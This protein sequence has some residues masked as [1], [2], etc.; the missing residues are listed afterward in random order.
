MNTR[1]SPTPPATG[2]IRQN[3]SASPITASQANSSSQQQTAMPPASRSGRGTTPSS[4]RSSLKPTDA[5]D[6]PAR[7]SSKDSLKQKMSKKL[8]EPPKPSKSEEQLKSL[9]SDFDNLRSHITCKIC[10]RLLYE[11]YIISCGH[12]YCYSCLCTWFVNNKNKTCPDCRAV[13]TQAPAP[14]YV[15]RDMT[16]IFIKRAELL[17][18]GETLEEHSKWQKEEADIVQ[19]D[20]SNEDP[21]TGGL[22]KG[23]FKPRV[24][25]TLRVIVD[26]E[27]GVE[28]CPLCSWELED[29][30]CAQCGL[31]FDDAGNVT[32]GDSFSGFSD[33][34]E[35][36][37]EHDMSDD[38]DAE[39]EDHYGFHGD[40]D[41][42]GFREYLNDPQNFVMGR[43]LETGIPPHEWA[44]GRRPPRSY[45]SA[46][47][48]RS[49]TQSIV[50]DIYGDEMDTVEEED[51]DGLDED[52]SMGDFIDDTEIGSSASQSGTSAASQTPQPQL[53]HSRP[54]GRVRRVVE[55]ETSSTTSS[56]IPEEDEDDEDEGPIRRGTRSRAHA[57]ILHRANGSR[58]P[59]STTSTET[60]TEQELDE[61]EQALLQEDGWML[62]HDDP[63]EEMDADED[64]ESDGGRTTV[65]WDATA[66]SNDRL[67]THGSLTPTADRP[68]PN[69]PI[70]PPSRVGNARFP[71]GSRGLRRRP[72]VLSTSTVHYED[73][74][75]DDDDSDMNG[76][77]DIDMAL[78]TLRVRRS[79]AQMRTSAAFNNQNNFTNRGFSQ[80]DLI[81]MDTDD[82]SDT[83]HRP[84]QRNRQSRTR[85]PE[86][87]PRIS[88]MF[89]DHQ[90]ELME[91]RNR[92][93]TPIARPR[94]ANR[95]RASPATQFSP[96]MPP[97]NAPTRLRT[98]LM[99]ASSNAETALRAGGP[100]S[101]PNRPTGISSNP[102]TSGLEHIWRMDRAVSAGAAVGTGT[103][104]MS[105]TSPIRAASH[106]SVNA[107]SQAQ[108]AAAVDM[109]DRPPSRVGARPPSTTGRRNSATF[110]PVY[111]GFGH[112]SIGLN[113]GNRLF[114]PQRG[115]PWG[116][117]VQPNGVRS[118]SSR[119]MLREQSSTAT[120]RASNS[121]ANLRDPVSP[122]AIVR[123]Q[124]SRINLRNQPSQRRL[125]NQSST[126]TLRASEHARPPHSPTTNTS[127][128]ISPNNRPLRITQ[129]E[130]VRRGR[131]LVNN[132]A[133]ELLG[134]NP[135]GPQPQRTNPFTSRAQ[136][137]GMSSREGSV[138]AGTS[139]AMNSHTHVRSNSNESLISAGSSSNMN[140]N[141]PSPHL[142]RRRSV[143]NIASAL[144]PSVY[145]AAQTTLSPQQ[146]S[147]PNAYARAR[148]GSLASNSAFDSPLSPGQRGMS[149]MVA[150]GNSG[151]Y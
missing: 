111:P 98:P 49:Y 117:F 124:T 6:K 76:E 29:G 10:D 16:L 92:S 138:I 141:P 149:P 106:S 82:N 59:P 151:R 17:P 123:T 58:P 31:R 37:E 43:F 7:H 38:L 90:R 42:E 125:N 5:G 54:Q 63:D 147:Y 137:P 146:A 28:R 136:R 60:S 40:F 67:R 96:F 114:Q 119:S 56:Q 99:S 84:S 9:K 50:S 62:H 89:A 102:A 133:T 91:Q 101:P 116:A 81:D 103:A 71:D 127:S 145:S 3:H 130:L 144:P 94:T 142:N 69:A 48:R 78:N 132:R 33:M 65:G 11:P 109:I 72:S 118:R 105:P 20:K 97:G 140:P 139:G 86:Y 134:T 73:G 85:H 8:E 122:P 24:G 39:M 13:V 36:S 14:A 131:E 143:R 4:S 68:R 110:S 113:M 35:L 23:C 108:A 52:S 129:D 70:R 128:P 30:E 53:N 51:E 46:G 15:I 112:T 34:D 75:A 150:A 121:R 107:T 126:R 66:N 25:H 93:T 80:G 88:W 135:P 44:A 87:D 32:Y 27:D 120:L 74:E 148:S 26:E 45:S 21:R 22:F 19:Q 55:S 47:S 41:E 2:S 57:G 115:N 77:G 64:D 83:S 1:H 18:H 100:T 104:T 79:R 95:N 12:T 61:D